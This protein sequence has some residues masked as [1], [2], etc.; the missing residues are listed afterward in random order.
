MTAGCLAVVARSWLR[1]CTVVVVVV[2][3]VV[4]VVVSPRKN[5]SLFYV[6]PYS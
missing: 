5:D 4:A 2:V 6:T 1:A 3:V